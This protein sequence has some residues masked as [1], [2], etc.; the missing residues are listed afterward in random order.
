MPAGLLCRGALFMLGKS[1]K[2]CACWLAGSVQD[3]SPAELL[4]QAISAGRE[5]LPPLALAN[6]RFCPPLHFRPHRSPRAAE[7]GPTPKILEGRE[8]KSEYGSRR[9]AAV[10]RMRIALATVP[11]RRRSYRRGLPRRATCS[12]SV[13]LGR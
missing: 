8:V 13:S 10:R 2:L 5:Q 1:C 4:R 9:L 12:E 3:V 7:W 6:K 11:V